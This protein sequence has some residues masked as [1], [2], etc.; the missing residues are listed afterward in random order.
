MLTIICGEDN[1][2]S[3][4]YFL[5]LK[6]KYK[7]NNC[8]INEI[9][10]NELLENFILEKNFN[11]FSQKTVYFIENLNKK[12]SDKNIKLKKN[13]DKIIDDNDLE[14]FDW[15]DGFNAR[16][17]KIKNKKI[18]VIEF[19]IKETVFK[20]LDE[21]MLGNQK[22]VLQFL[23]NLSFEESFLFIM[24]IRH[25]RNLLL[26]KTGVKPEKLAD[27]Q[28]NKLKFQA[29]LWPLSK[30]IQIYKT[31][32]RIDIQIKTSQT[33]FSLKESLEILSYYF[34]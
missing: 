27:W 9:K 6:K 14:L 26:I 5:S 20:F 16:E 2:A 28:I 1:I 31:L 23:V 21:F 12:Y 29:K 30:L 13:L 19:K 15:E 25:I 34:L 3:R 8:Q 11:L 33:P 10:F 22:K 32:H 4:N 24:L 7:E 17:L 18:K